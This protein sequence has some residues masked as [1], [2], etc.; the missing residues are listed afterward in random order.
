MLQCLDDHYHGTRGL[1]SYSS[2]CWVNVTHASRNQS[3]S[4]DMRL[5]QVVSHSF[6]LTSR[7]DL[8]VAR[9]GV[10]IHRVLLDPAR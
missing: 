7:H 8:A 1:C 10:T 3:T 9:Y 2:R 6:E 5:Y 4:V